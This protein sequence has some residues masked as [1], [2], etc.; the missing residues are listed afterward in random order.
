MSWQTKTIAALVL[1][2]VLAG[3]IAWWVLPE[4][5]QTRVEKS[6]LEYFGGNCSVEVFSGGQK[7]R[8]Y[9]VDGYIM[10]ERG[11]G[12]LSSKAAIG[13]RHDGVLTFK[14]KQG[15]HIRVGAWGSTILVECK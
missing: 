4:R 10:F 8:D 11:D 6:V 14:D 1:L 15:R 5:F 3:V 7:I 9:Q 13:G 12:D 2:L